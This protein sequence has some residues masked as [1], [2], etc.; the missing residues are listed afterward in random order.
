M[1]QKLPGCN[2]QSGRV[3]CAGSTGICPLCAAYRCLSR[4]PLCSNDSLL[5]TAARNGIVLPAR[6]NASQFPQ[7]SPV[8]QRREISPSLRFRHHLSFSS[9]PLRSTQ[10]RQARFHPA[11][12]CLPAQYR[13]LLC[14][15]R[16]RHLDQ[17]PPG[18]RSIPRLDAR[19]HISG[20]RRNAHSLPEI[21]LTIIM[22]SIRPSN[23]LFYTI[24][25]QTNQQSFVIIET[26]M[27]PQPGSLMQV[28]GELV[29]DAEVSS[30]S[31]FYVD[32]VLSVW[33]P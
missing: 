21:S 32:E 1:D 4:T 3:G 20:F 31:F 11:R 26:E 7:T 6:K 33:K 27:L 25:L 12:N 18:K 8:N 10:K 15:L 28:C 14:K 19:L 9:S 24:D 5:H 17:Y 29:F 30:Y 16:Q 23:T 13:Y 22:E 2:R